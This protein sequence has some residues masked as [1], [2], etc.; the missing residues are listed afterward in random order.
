M[1]KT[2]K[3]F[4]YD[5]T[6]AGDFERA[7][8]KMR[9]LEVKL[10]S[11]RARFAVPFIFRGRG[12]FKSIEPRQNPS[13]FESLFAIVCDMKPS[14]VLEI[15]TARGGALYL[16]CQAATDDARIVSVDL[17]SVQG[18]TGGYA[19]Q[20]TAF[21]QAFA[22]AKQKLELL[23]LDTHAPAAREQVAELFADQQADFAYIDRD[24]TL[25]GVRSDFM[26]Y[27]P[28]VRPGG[29]IAF[30]DILP[31]RDLPSM[32]VHQFWNELKTR[33]NTTTE[34][35]GPEGSGRQIGIGILRVPATGIRP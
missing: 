21:Y 10:P 28:L 8:T 2:F 1:S 19:T 9:Q 27:G 17:P 22:R 11:A 34:L 16:W 32:Q 4:A 20:R 23:R 33:Y 14:R 7:I 18:A 15:G 25:D 12:H 3:S 5:L 35:I 30:H 24:H 29:L 31:R 26:Q 13:E 6:A